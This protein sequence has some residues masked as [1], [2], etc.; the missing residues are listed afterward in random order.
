MPKI[1]IIIPIYNAQDYLKRCLNSV[2]NQTL[3]DIEIICVNDASTDNSLKILNCYAKS[4]SNIKVIDCKE[5]GGESKARNI[6]LENATGEY[7]AFLDNDDCIDLDFYE[8]LYSLAISK[9]LDIAKADCFEISIDGKKFKQDDNA[10]IKN[11]DKFAFVTHWWTA[12]FK[13]EIIKKNNIKFREDIILGG[14]IIFLNEVLLSSKSFE[15]IDSTY[16]YHYQQNNSGDSSFLSYEKVQS[17][18]KSYSIII[19]NLN[20]N[21]QENVTK[22]GYCYAVAYYLQSIYSR[23]SKNYSENVIRLCVETVFKLLENVKNDCI[24]KQNLS[25]YC[26]HVVYYFEKKDKNELISLLL[27]SYNLTFTQLLRYKHKLKLLKGDK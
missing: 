10:Q 16:Y 17:A 7:L 14:D 11:N 25:N 24:I 5:N 4:Y 27:K 23:I 6:G 20:K 3:Q 22:I 19:E 2:V 26:P 18:V 15:M 1:S 21:Y 12:I 9:E 13:R 8:K